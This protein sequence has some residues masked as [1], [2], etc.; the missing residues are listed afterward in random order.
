MLKEEGG[1][2]AHFG[3]CRDIF[4]FK[5]SLLSFNINKRNISL[6]ATQQAHITSIF[7]NEGKLIYAL[8][9]HYS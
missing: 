7:K 2:N 5:G 3:L 4:L 8:D 1:Q 6:N 9:L